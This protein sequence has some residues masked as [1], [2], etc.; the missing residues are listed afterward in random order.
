MKKLHNLLFYLLTCAM[1]LPVVESY[2]QDFEVSAQL[3]P[4]FEYRH[5]Y[6]T[7]MPENVDPAMFVSQRTRLNFNFANEKF[8]TGFSIQDVRVWG[9]VSQLNTSDVNGLSIHQAWGEVFLGKKVSIKLGRQEIIYDDSRIFGNV[10]WAQQARSHD[11]LIIK[12][13]AK[14]E[15]KLDIGVAYNANSESLYK[16]EYMQ[17][18]YRTMQYI[19]WHRDIGAFGLGLIAPGHCTG[20]RALNALVT[21]YGEGVVA[22]LAVGKIFEIQ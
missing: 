5:G 12:I 14:E 10:N 20:W 3:R 6:K 15:C 2:A 9:D 7:L 8:K 22:P 18:S 4:R 17:K 1:L 13:R 19:H 16:E 21:E 11:A